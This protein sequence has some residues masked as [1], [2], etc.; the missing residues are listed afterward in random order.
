MKSISIT[1]ALKYQLKNATNYQF[2][3]DKQCFNVKSGRRIK[4]TYCG[5]SIGYCINGK[6]R[7][8]KS[9]RNELEII[10]KID[11]PF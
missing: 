2:T 6:F 7:S 3:T 8:L 5:G 11:C 1:Y 10:P 4:Q 9:L